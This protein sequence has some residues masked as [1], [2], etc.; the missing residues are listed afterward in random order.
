MSLSAIRRTGVLQAT[1]G[2][3]KMTASMNAPW[4]S[5]Q[6]CFCRLN[7]KSVFESRFP[8]RIGSRPGFRE[9]RYWPPVDPEMDP[10]TVWS[11]GD[12]WFDKKVSRSVAFSV[13]LR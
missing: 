10:A 13:A 4:I 12:G 9:I 7:E 1:Q 6:P 2:I 8:G 11:D 5:S 3:Q